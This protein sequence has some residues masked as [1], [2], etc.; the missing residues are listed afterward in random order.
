MGASSSSNPSVGRKMLRSIVI[1][2]CIGWSTVAAMAQSGLGWVPYQNDRFGFE[3]R[4][5]AAVFTDHTAAQSGDGDLFTTS[6]GRAKLLVGAIENID[7]HSPATYQRF[8]TRQS[9]PGLRVDYAPVGRTW[10][11]LSGSRGGRMIYEKVMFSCGG[12]VINSFALVYPIH[13]RQFFDPIVEAIEDSFRPGLARCR[14]HA[15]AN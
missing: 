7:D 14:D 4:L 9:Y 2:I 13:E 5:P 1:V 10:A 6:D 11:V 12:R 3:L 15:S 8:L